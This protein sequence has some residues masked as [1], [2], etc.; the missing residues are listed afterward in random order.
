MRGIIQIELN[1]MQSFVFFIFI[2]LT[3]LLVTALLSPVA[4]AQMTDKDWEQQQISQHILVSSSTLNHVYKVNAKMYVHATPDEFFK[5]LEN[6]H[7]D[8][9][10]I[11]NCKRVEILN[12][13][14]S[15][16]RFVHTIFNS[17]WP[18]ADREMYTRSF[19]QFDSSHQHLTI[20]IEDI[21]NDYPAHPQR[22][23]MN[24]VTAQW[25]MSHSHDGW[26][27]LNYLASAQP[28]GLIPN[29][30]SKTLLKQATADTFAQLRER[31][32]ADKTF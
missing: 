13:T 6:A 12:N 11:A 18:V 8:C 20:F 22:V 24:N 17:P 27:E 10:W 1:L 7:Q 26:Y 9:S 25:S 19:H 32:H 16:Y 23:M 28:G 21:S 5:I 29:W 15:N 4:L 30:L 3:W 14:L 31:L 2:N